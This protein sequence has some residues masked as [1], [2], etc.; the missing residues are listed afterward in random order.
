MTIERATVCVA[1]MA[2][3]LLGLGMATENGFLMAAGVIM[4]F[5]VAFGMCPMFHDKENDHD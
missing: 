1:W 4:M 5:V 3:F 2:G